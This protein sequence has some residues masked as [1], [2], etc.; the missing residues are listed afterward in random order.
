[1]MI[2]ATVR[3]NFLGGCVRDWMGVW[4]LKLMC[5]HTAVYMK[6]QELKQRQVFDTLALAQYAA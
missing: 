1:M 4:L 6:Q 3:D 2:G 5:E